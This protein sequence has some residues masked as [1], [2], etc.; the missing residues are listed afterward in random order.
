M[1]DF[2]AFI[3]WPL[4]VGDSSAQTGFLKLYIYIYVYLNS[5]LHDL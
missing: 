2:G 1:L 5:N 4:A 3:R